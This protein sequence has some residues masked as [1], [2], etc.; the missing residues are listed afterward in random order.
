MSIQVPDDTDKIL[1]TLIKASVSVLEDAPIHRRLLLSGAIID[2][3]D[4][5]AEIRGT[6]RIDTHAAAMKVI[7][8]EARR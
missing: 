5:L 3:K 1:D 2:A 8:D 4:L 7:H 6:E